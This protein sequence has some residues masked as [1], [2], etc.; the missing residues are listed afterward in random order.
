[1]AL[2]FPRREAEARVFLDANP[3]IQSVHVVWTDICGVARGK[4]QIGRAS[5]RERV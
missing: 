2:V 4:I 1:M 3:D 5:C